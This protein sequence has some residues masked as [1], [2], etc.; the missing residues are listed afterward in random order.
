MD[1]PYDFDDATIE[2]L[3]NG[4]GSAID[5]DLAAFIADLRIAATSQLPTPRADLAVLI[6]YGGTTTSG[7][8]PTTAGWLQS[9]LAKI[10]AAAAAVFAA[11]SGLAV[12]GALP[13]P[14]QHA[15]SDIG[16]GSRSPRPA[17]QP[18]TDITPTT[19]SAP[20]ST[21][22]APTARTAPTSTPDTNADDSNGAS[23]V[24]HDHNVS[25]CQHGHD[26]ANTASNGKAKGQ[27]CDNTSTRTPPRD[28][29]PG[30]QATNNPSNNRNRQHGHAS[31]DTSPANA[32]NSPSGGANNGRRHDGTN[33]GGPNA[34]K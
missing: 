10:A 25:G 34:S 15:L 3:I 18:V 5:P 2:A 23:S 6:G 17:H 19:T 26:V 11:T 24:A 29:T 13:A 12:A 4:T 27:P 21:T 9:R 7:A 1:E 30:S 20:T 22:V 14:V 28:N 31:N 33:T 16:I 8:S 32:G